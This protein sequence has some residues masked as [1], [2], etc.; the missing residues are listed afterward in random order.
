MILI[1]DETI[2]ARTEKEDHAVIELL[3]QDRL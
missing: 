3:F 2:R 1:T